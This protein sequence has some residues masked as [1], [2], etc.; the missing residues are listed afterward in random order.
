MSNLNIDLFTSSTADKE[1]SE[2]KVLAA[3]KNYA[4]LMH[5]NI[6]YPTLTEVLEIFDSLANVLNQRDN[7][8]FKHARKIAGIDLENEKFLY[9]YIDNG[10]DLNISGIFEFIEWTLPKIKEI[11]DEG[12]AIF[13]FVEAH[14]QIKEIG[15]IPIYKNEGYFFVPDNTKK[16][17]HVFRFQ[18]SDII[19]SDVQFKTLKTNLIELVDDYPVKAAPEFIKLEL[20]K[21]YDDL[22]NPATYCV[23]TELDMPFAETIL[24]IAKRKIIQKVAA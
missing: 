3:L 6:L 13:D 20:I 14:M 7:Y 1:L 23:I 21:K 2:Y 18:L 16:E 10:T 9:D 19:Y 4:Q 5:K 8:E 24:P 17:T 22:P 11:I 12:T 15:L